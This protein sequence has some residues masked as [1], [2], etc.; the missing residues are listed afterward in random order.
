METVTVLTTFSTICTAVVAGLAARFCLVMRC[1]C[2]PT[3]KN[4]EIF[5]QILKAEK[6]KKMN[7]KN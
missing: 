6:S 3:K 7:L 1:V 4:V 2:L 5:K